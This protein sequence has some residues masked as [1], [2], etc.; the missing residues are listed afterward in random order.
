[1]SGIGSAMPFNSNESLIY[2]IIGSNVPQTVA[3]IKSTDTLSAPLF[4]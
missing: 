2:D 1:M 3:R 4:A